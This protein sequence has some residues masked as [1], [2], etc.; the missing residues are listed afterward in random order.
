MLRRS[1]SEPAS[2]QVAGTTQPDEEGKAL[3]EAWHQ[4]QV[5]RDLPSRN[6]TP[7]APTAV[8]ESE[9][10][11]VLRP[12]PRTAPPRAAGASRLAADPTMEQLAAIGARIVH[13]IELRLDAEAQDQLGAIDQL[14]KRLD[15]VTRDLDDV[16]RRLEDL[17]QLLI[18]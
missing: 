13:Q 14:A 8:E 3:E 5:T 2:E 17:H 1:P 16:R 11:P 10:A 6:D 15:M 9:A 12:E 4:W 18:D 7:E